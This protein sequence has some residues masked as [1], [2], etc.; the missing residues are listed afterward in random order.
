MLIPV[1]CISYVMCFQ[2]IK[3]ASISAQL[4]YDYYSMPFCKPADI[5]YKKQ[6]LGLFWTLQAVRI[7][8]EYMSLLDLLNI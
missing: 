7:I 2:A 1:L 6:S 4:P 5:H 8:N 3:I